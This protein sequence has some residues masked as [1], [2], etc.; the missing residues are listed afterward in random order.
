M[1]HINGILVH[2][3]S[4]M[5]LLDT[6]QRAFIKAEGCADNATLIDLVLRQQHTNHSSAYIASIDLAK[7][8]DSLTHAAIF[9]TMNSYGFPQTLINFITEGYLNGVTQFYGPN[10]TSQ[11][12][13]QGRG[14]KQGDPLP[15]L[16]FNLI[17]D[18][19]LKRLPS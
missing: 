2:R 5:M 19:L 17:I 1:R 18:R 15:P 4:D 12:L 3:L 13:K 6:R 16:Q 7:A 9:D 14:V 11:E 10:W 8:F